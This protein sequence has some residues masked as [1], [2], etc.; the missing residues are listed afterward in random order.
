[1]RR[2]GPGSPPLCWLLGGL[3]VHLGLIGSALGA[4]PAPSSSAPPASA[5]GAAVPTA[6]PA[7]NPPPPPPPGPTPTAA[8][9]MNPP[10]PPPPGPVPT[11]APVMDPAPPPPVVP[12]PAPAPNPFTIGYSFGVRVGMRLQ[13]PDK[14]SNMSEVHLDSQAYDATVEARFHGAVTDNFSWVA[15]FNGNLTAGTLA[16]PGTVGIMDL[17]AQYK[18]SKEFNIWAGRLLVPSDRSNFCGPFFSIPWNYPGFY[19]LNAAPLGPKDGPTGRDQGATVWGNA[20]EDKLKYYVGL[21]GIDKLGAGTQPYGSARLSYS[22]QGS[23][24]GYFGSSTYYGAKNVVTIAVGGQYQKDGLVDLNTMAPKDTVTFMAD[25][26]AEE[27]VN[28]AGTFTFEGDFYKFTDGYVFAS[29]P[30]AVAAPI[31][32]PGEAF[33]VEGAWLTPEPIGI[34][35]LQPLVRLQQTMDRRPARALGPCSTGPSPTSSR[36]TPVASS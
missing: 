16:V 8:P 29:T 26:F 25:V 4:E 19:F 11:A 34:G 2:R 14:P 36:T 6:A 20:V 31:Y 35:R 13:D 15:N 27:N 33:Y 5:A 21:Y 30:T 12:P 17:I 18:A 9:A 24:P 23:E 10:P 28:G 32:A 7:M 22:L 1:M 3:C